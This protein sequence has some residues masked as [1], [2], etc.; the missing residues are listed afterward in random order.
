VIPTSTSIIFITLYYRNTKNLISPI[1][2]TSNV[3]ADFK[4][5]KGTGALTSNGLPFSMMSDSG[6]NMSSKV[7]YERVQDH[8]G[9]GGYMRVYYQILP[10]SGHEGFVGVYADFTLP[11]ATP[12]SLN[13]YNGIEFRMRISQESGVPPEVRAVLY[14]DNIKNMEYAYPIARVQPD[15]NWRNYD[16]PFN[17]FE[18]PPHA[19]SHIKLDPG[20]VFRFA[21][22]FV[23][24][25]T[26]HGH[27]DIDEI[28][29]YE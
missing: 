14:S 15:N 7:W 11:P 4:G 20:R 24:D 18:A 22:V 28:K 17:K 19:I 13:K 16:I 9:S 25:K 8:L 27:I 2:I 12:V 6:L 23:S 10:S 26:I 1:T 21:F 29:L 3:I 5:S